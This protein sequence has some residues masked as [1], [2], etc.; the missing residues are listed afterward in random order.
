M[1]DRPP[2]STVGETIDPTTFIT[3][4]KKCLVLWGSL[5][6]V[7]IVA[8]VLGGVFGSKAV[9][10]Q[11]RPI[12]IEEVTYTMITEGLMS[13]TI[14]P[15]SIS[16]MMAQ[17]QQE[18][19]GNPTTS[20]SGSP[21]T[22]TTTTAPASNT[23]A[24][25]SGST[26]S[27][28]STTSSG[29]TTSSSISLFQRFTSLV[30]MSSNKSQFDP[31]AMVLPEGAVAVPSWKALGDAT[32]VQGQAVA[33]GRVVCYPKTGKDVIVMASGE[34]NSPC[35]VLILTND[36][37]NAY[38][39]DHTVNITSPKLF[40]GRPIRPPMLNCTN[41]IVRLFDVQSGGRLEIRAVT[42]VRGF[43]Y[44][45]GPDNEITV[46]AGSI[47]RV[48]V[49]GYFTA[50]G[51]LLRERNNTRRSFE[52]EVRRVILNPMTRG[53]QF[54]QLILVLGGRLHLNGCTYSFFLTLPYVPFSSPHMLLLLA[55]Y[56]NPAFFLSF[57]FR[58]PQTL[59]RPPSI[60]L[61]LSSPPASP[62]QAP[63]CTC[64]H[65]ARCLFHITAF[66][67]PSSH[68]SCF[69]LSIFS[70]SPFPSGSSFR[71]RPFGNGV[72]NNMLIGRDINVVAGY[73][74][75]TGHMTCSAALWTTSFWSTGSLGMAMGGVIV[76]VGG[77]N[78]GANLMQVQVG[79][80]CI[81][82]SYGGVMATIGWQYTSTNGVLLRMNGGQFGVLTGL[83][84]M[85]GFVQGRAW[86]IAAVF[87]PGQSYTAGAGMYIWQGGATCSY[88]ISTAFFGVGA[89]T[90][91]GAGTGIFNGIP[92]IRATLTSSSSG[93]GFYNF[94]GAGTL[95]HIFL[96]SYSV[97]LV[98]F[99][100]GAGTDFFVGMGWANN[101]NC[102]RF[103][104]QL[105]NSFFGFG[106]QVF[107]GLGGAVFIRS[108]SNSRRLVNFG[109][110]TKFTY[111][112]GGTGVKSAG[113]KGQNIVMTKNG[114]TRFTFN[115]TDKTVIKLDQNGAP[116]KALST[117]IGGGKW[118]RKMSAVG[119]RR[120]AQEGTDATVA[121]SMSSWLKDIVDSTGGVDPAIEGHQKIVVLQTTIMEGRSKSFNPPHPDMFKS[122]K[123]KNRWGGY[124]KI[125][126]DGL[127]EDKTDTS[128]VESRS[129]MRDDGTRGYHPG[130]I[131]ANNSDCF[132]CSVKP[133]RSSDHIGGPGSCEVYDNCDAETPAEVYVQAQ[134]LT[135]KNILPPN[136]DMVM[137]QINKAG[138]MIPPSTWLL[139]SELV[140]YCK[141]QDADVDDAIIMEDC[142]TKEY[143]TEVIKS[144]ISLNATT[145]TEYQITVGPAG[146]HGAAQLPNFAPDAEDVS[147]SDLKSVLAPAWNPDCQGWTK[148][149]IQV[150]SNQPE[151]EQH[152]LDVFME[153]YNDPTDLG[154][155]IMSNWD[156][157]E[158]MQPCG[159]T[160]AE[161]GEQRFPS[162]KSCPAYTPSLTSVLAPSMT[163]ADDVS[164]EP[165][166]Q[167]MPNTTYKI[168]IQNFPEGSKVEIKLLNGLEKDGPV[169][170][171]INSF[172]DNGLSK[173][174]W[175][176]PKED[177]D[178]S[179]SKYYLQAQSV[180]FP[181]LFAFSQLFS[182][183]DPSL[184][185]VPNPWLFDLK[186]L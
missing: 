2:N 147:I 167:V 59:P 35:E 64:I 9:D 10:E 186:D 163:L 103:S 142:L 89:S 44:S 185:S 45:T 57:T 105:A 73:A 99:N 119:V 18:G 12:P 26:T 60:S 83:A 125:M 133:G 123:L 48:H 128:G 98:R 93:C 69:S 68:N 34:F 168:F 135:S 82:G 157:R 159:V 134:S 95:T 62:T 7:L 115:K 47:C 66:I 171:T 162:L 177:V 149:D 174:A 88:A 138:S 11:R 63:P 132:L 23:L 106:N 96:P 56:C 101:I 92:Q 130:L 86:G 118:R 126:G 136:A 120:G 20:I 137:P 169:I 166:R 74:V 165:I 16:V 173:V 49:G 84:Y 32:F 184:S 27:S 113:T 13:A 141:H 78:V 156:E 8:A 176:V 29:S 145:G 150:T 19:T 85:T 179:K 143:V 161:K 76:F 154:E 41:R 170:A 3:R 72:I 129:L 155:T 79:W 30:G 146:L 91:I 75:V 109:W 22:S 94:V 14:Q 110:P 53:R 39:I 107:I 183:K 43:G 158:D 58:I 160:V 17:V 144:F 87:G 164:I 180:D 67:H 111:T 117:T 140:V 33:S 100:A 121:H 4:S 97:N 175:T 181:A 80:A 70:S 46:T 31:T 153:F 90:Y 71:F 42:L 104:L 77:S 172:D 6:S 139:W 55:T 122:A 25:G 51:C 40:L 65:S 148:Y 114:V 28:D 152:L 124:A 24:N 38:Q 178:I 54:G 1:F 102:T 5:A 112:V 52:D 15:I 81:L 108:Y 131:S 116:R 127:V 182:F 151:A 21:A 50:T 61:L 37:Y 36:N